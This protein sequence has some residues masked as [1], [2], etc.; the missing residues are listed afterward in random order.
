[1]FPAGLV[2]QTHLGA[3]ICK[4]WELRVTER[5]LI[6]DL[7]VK[8]DTPF[9]DIRSKPIVK[10]LTKRREQR[11]EDSSQV[12][13]LTSG[14]EVWVLRQG[15]DH[16][17]GTFFHERYRVV[18][19]LAYGL[20]RSG[21]PNDFFPY[22]KALD[23]DK[24]LLPGRSDI[25]RLIKERAQRFAYAVRIEAPALLRQAREDGVEIK[26]MLGGE[27]GACVSLE[28]AA[29]IEETTIAYVPGTM[30]PEY[31]AVVLAAFHPGPGWEPTDRL[32]SRALEP[33]EVAWAHMHHA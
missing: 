28:C 23:A 4:E 11:Y 16:R 25:S 8:A 2:G 10:A 6:E 24:R 9:E 21:A 13:P 14:H 27:F 33:Y 12:T 3:Y 26:V 22:C 32:P 29:D 31:L 7:D 17:G 18:W 15:N 19:L 1:M 20:H 30:R 5:C